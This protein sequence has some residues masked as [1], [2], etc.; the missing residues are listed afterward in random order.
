MPPAWACSRNQFNTTTFPDI[1]T[2][3]LRLVF[4]SAGPASTGLLQWRV[5][6]TGASPNFP[7]SVAAGVDRVVVQPG[8]TYLSGTVKDDGKP[9]PVP[10][11]R[12]TRQSGP[13]SVTFG[14]AAAALATARFSAPGLYV[15]KLS[16]DDGQLT[17]SD[18]LNVIVD[19]PPPPTHLDTVWTNSLPDHQPVLE[20]SLQEPSRQLDSSLR[21]Q[22]R[23]S[24]T[25]GRRS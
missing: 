16:A 21:Q 1:T 12:W 5:Y 11:V 10:T 19:P 25:A 13:G 23:R 9:N 7:P 20:Q 6:D 4:D 8:Q 2:S 14:D 17:A 15:L 3:K 22:N 24:R 18:T